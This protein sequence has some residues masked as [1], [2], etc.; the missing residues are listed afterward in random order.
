MKKKISIFDFDQTL[1]SEH[2][3][4]KFS[5]GRFS[6]LPDNKM[7]EIGLRNQESNRKKNFEAFFKH[8]DNEL[9]AIATFHNNPFFIAGFVAGLLNKPLTLANTLLSSTEP[10]VA[11]SIYVIDN[12]TPPFL[13][14]F[15]PAL[16]K[17][18]DQTISELEIRKVQKNYQIDFLCQTLIE[19]GYIDYDTIIDFYDDDPNNLSQATALLFHIQT[20]Q[21]SPG[22]IFQ[23]SHSD[24]NIP[25]TQL[26]PYDETKIT[27][28]ELRINQY[29]EKLN[30]S[31]NFFLRSP[32]EK[33]AV[34]NE[35]IG[36]LKDSDEDQ[37][38]IEEAFS[39]WQDKNRRIISKHRNRFFG[40]KRPTIT[41]RTTMFIQDLNEELKKD[42]LPV[43]VEL[44]PRGR[45]PRD[46]IELTRTKC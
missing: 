21:V 6:S 26:N 24:S 15:I 2:T 35:L 44:E 14:S 43:E 23:I 22:K 39:D 33:V 17:T 41:T 46:S 40:E 19:G 11:I 1:T 8:D 29:I 27:A 20:H 45:R 4:Q 37:K 30:R 10:Q 12:C 18:Y 3:F 38:T 16:G 7:Y 31:L 5:K 13:I 42:I 32:K 34:L 36:E 25:T 28:L 9:S